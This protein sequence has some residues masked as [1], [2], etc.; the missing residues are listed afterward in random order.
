[1]NTVDLF[2]TAFKYLF[3]FWCLVS[4]SAGA[5][6][7]YHELDKNPPKMIPFGIIIFALSPFIAWHGVIH[8]YELW[9]KGHLK[10]RE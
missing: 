5:W 8:Y 7:F 3:I 4:Y 2:F 9:K 1:M 6:L 10:S